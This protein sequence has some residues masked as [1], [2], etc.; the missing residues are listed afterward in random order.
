[1]RIKHRHHKNRDGQ[2]NYG[3]GQC[4][5]SPASEKPVHRASNLMP[6]IYTVTTQK[7]SASGLAGIRRQLTPFDQPVN[8]QI[9]PGPV[10][11]GEDQRSSALASPR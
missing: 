7:H 5:K 11:T 6:E 2:P 10:V 1:M 3:G 8:V 9:G 4:R